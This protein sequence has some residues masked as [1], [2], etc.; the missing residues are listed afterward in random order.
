LR[1]FCLLLFYAAMLHAA[2]SAANDFA[3]ERDQ[4]EKQT[5]ELGGYLEATAEH[6]RANRDAAVYRFNFP[7]G[8]RTSFERYQGN[9]ELSGLYRMESFSLHGLLDARLRDDF[10]ETKGD[11]RFY[12]LY[13]AA[14]PTLRTG[15]EIGKR[16]LRW[17]TGYAFNP[18]GFLERPK[19]PNDPD[20]SREGF[21]IAGTEVIR[22]FPGSSLQALSLNAIILPVGN[23]INDDFGVEN[24]INLAARIYLLYRDTDVFFMVRHGES[25]PSALGTAFSRNLA[26]NIEIHGEA[27]WFDS[28]QLR[29]GDVGGALSFRRADP[30]DLLAGFRCLTASET[31]WIVEYYRNGAGY[32]G[33][34][35]RRMADRDAIRLGRQEFG[36]PHPMHDYLYIRAIRN[37]P[38]TWLYTRGGASTMVNLRD[39]S[40]SITPEIMYSGFANLELRGRIAVLTGGRN[41]DFGERLNRWRMEL[42]GRYYF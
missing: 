33:S 4:Y 32:T 21:I 10:L 28:R 26:D 15:V 42:R 19:D 39:G 40:A 35:M 7:K 8:N 18:T 16:A 14:Q 34:E 12:Q 25:R 22:S 27:A 6:L 5:W 41:T 23:G 11:V 31:T 3:F 17:G 2:T 1:K 9:F 36:A 37:E 20:L 38:F 13:A 29:V 30:I 24:D